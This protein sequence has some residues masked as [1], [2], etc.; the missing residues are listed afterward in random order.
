MSEALFGLIMTL[1]FTGTLSVISGG[2]EE[3]RT[4]ILSILGCNIAWG[5]I[6][7]VLYLLGAIG[8]RGHRIGMYH[9]I[10]EAGGPEETRRALAEVLPEEIAAGLSPSELDQIRLRVQQQPDAVRRARLGLQDVGAAVSV[11][12]FVVLSCVPVVVPFLLITDPIPALRTSNAVAL[13]MLFVCGSALARYAGLSTFWTGV[14][15]VAVGAVMV[16]ITIALGG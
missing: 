3:V 8:E 10:R 12:L 11:F 14:S 4:M 2:T 1:S 7:A 5:V 13:V 16:G 15:M 6:D 9:A